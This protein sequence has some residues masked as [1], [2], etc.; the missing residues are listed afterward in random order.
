MDNGHKAHL[1]GDSVDDPKEICAVRL[2]INDRDRSEDIGE[3]LIE[4]AR[5]RSDC[6]LSRQI[7]DEMDVLAL[8]SAKEMRAYLDRYVELLR[9]RNC[10]DT[11]QFVFSARPG[12]AGRILYLIRRF[13]WKALRYQHDWMAFRQN[14]INVQLTYEL[15]FEKAA[16]EKDVKALEERIDR[17]ESMMDGKA[18]GKERKES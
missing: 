16:R 4:T 7:A 14:A 2:L 5:Q 12:L 10:V 15:E 3:Q 18:G 8:K 1:Q 17:L 11:D 6:G 13:L 9:S